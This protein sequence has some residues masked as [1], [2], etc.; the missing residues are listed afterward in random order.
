MTT[1]PRGRKGRS[2]PPLY[3]V[4]CNSANPIV[5]LAHATE[6]IDELSTHSWVSH[7][8]G[9]WLVETVHTASEIRDRLAEGPIGA[10]DSVI[11]V[12][13]AEDWAA[14]GLSDDL[15]LLLDQALRR[16]G[17]ETRP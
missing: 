9:F 8:W 11:V 10:A 13:V 16:A 3:A 12:K 5:T 4:S 17:A 6:A 2:I 1:T 15:S 7:G 14:V